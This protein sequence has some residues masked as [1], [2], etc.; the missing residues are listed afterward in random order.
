MPFLRRSLPASRGETFAVERR[1]PAVGWGP[2][3]SSGLPVSIAALAPVL[4]FWNLRFDVWFLAVVASLGLLGLLLVWRRRARAESALR[5]SEAKFAGMVAIATDAIISVDAQQRITDFNR[6]AEAIFGYRAE[7]IIGE[8]L[9]RLLPGRF[10]EAHSGHIA[11]FARSPTVARRMGERGD[12]QIVG[13]RQNGQEFPAEASISKMRIGDQWI[14]TVVLR[15]VTTRRR[16]ERAQA[17]L[18]KAG[19]LLASSLDYQTTLHSVVQLA[20]SDLA[21]WC[22]IYIRQEDGS[23]QRLDAA[24]SDPSRDPLIQS[25]AQLPLRL[26]DPHPA[27]RAME[28]GHVEL[29]RVMPDN[30]GEVLAESEEQIEMVRELG[31]RSAVVAPLVA[32]GRTLGAIGLYSGQPG[33]YDA[34]D[35]DLAE[36][37]ARRAALAVDNAALYREAQ[38]AINAR[39]EVLSVVSHDLGNP[40]SAVFINTRLLLKRV[41]GMPPGAPEVQQVEG[42]RQAAEQMQR[43]IKDLLDVQR[44]EAGRLSLDVAPYP[45][46][47]ILAEAVERIEPL[48]GDKEQTL[49]LDAD[50][51]CAVRV[52]R[53]RVL[54]MLGNLLGNAIKFTPVGGEVAV[55]AHRDD[56][57]VLVT[58]GD[59]GPG[60]APADLPHVFDR[61][62]QSTRPTRR[63]SGLGLAIAKGIVD[64]HGGDI[65]IDSELGAGTTVRV[66]LPIA[67]RPVAEDGDDG[68][69][70]DRPPDSAPTADVVT[71]GAPADDAAGLDGG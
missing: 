64:A 30:L 17:F 69:S 37:L 2:G 22:V 45:I 4:S 29:I 35:A 70:D 19:A 65:S 16:E 55:E 67:E 42:I 8:P 59:T 46:G 38:H 49:T 60:I 62:Y 11:G 5:F 48:A 66:S 71:S 31:M 53:D 27:K 39:N 41:A 23:I 50:L 6:G 44:I 36:E 18:A 56:R 7:E 47:R 34:R 15:D 51:E 26:R 9:G 61:F 40:L 25:L 28:R 58:V 10:R 33:R 24:H 3:A 57:H 63:G 54:Q 43:L 13:L 68:S 1:G 21:D 14:F 52:D 32:R 12:V 20:A